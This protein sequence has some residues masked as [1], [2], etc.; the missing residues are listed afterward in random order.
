MGDAIS[1][2]INKRY[3]N[4]TCTSNQAGFTIIDTIADKKIH[5][6]Y[7]NNGTKKEFAFDD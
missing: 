6:F 2:A 4:M 7:P 5:T 1:E 3:S